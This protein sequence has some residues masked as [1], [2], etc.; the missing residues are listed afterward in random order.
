[1]SIDRSLT[2][3]G[4]AP[5]WLVAVIAVVAIAAAGVAVVAVRNLRA[6]PPSVPALRLALVPPDDL[7]VGGGTD[8]PFGLSLAPDGRRL[9]FP[10]A[11]QGATQ[12]WLLDLTT[13]D[14]QSLPGTEDGVLPF[15]APDGRAVGF[16]AAGRLRLFA[17]ED[18][19]VRDLADAPAPRGAAWHPNGDIV[20]APDAEGGLVR[21]KSDGRI[22]AFSALEAGE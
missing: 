1:M 13:G 19:K 2:S 11:R 8:Y 16:F 9:V 10:A 5:L 6:R 21:R 22:E 12:L 3:T 15:W 4:R 20:F 7:T 18:G 14:R 17:F